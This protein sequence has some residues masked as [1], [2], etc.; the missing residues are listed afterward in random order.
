MTVVCGEA[1]ADPCVAGHKWAVTTWS[2]ALG[3]DERVRCAHAFPK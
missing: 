1:R 2:R 3:G